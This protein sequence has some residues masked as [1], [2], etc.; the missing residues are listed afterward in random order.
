MKAT[1]AKG[2]HLNGRA[3][4]VPEEHVIVGGVHSAEQAQGLRNEGVSG[5]GAR[6]W[7]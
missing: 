3:E 2:V 6:R 1:L 5:S 7:R 4:V